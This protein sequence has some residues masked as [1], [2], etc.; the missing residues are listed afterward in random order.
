MTKKFA[1]LA[2]SKSIDKVSAQSGG[3][4]GWFEDGNMVKEFSNV[5][6]SLKNGELTKNPVKTQFGYHVIL[7]EKSEAKKQLSY[8]EVKGAIEQQ[9]KNQEFQQKLGAKIQEL[10]QKAKI[11]IK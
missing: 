7:K 2:T 4:L 8:D 11:E 3:S 5:A 9:L 1:E 10:Y 6:F